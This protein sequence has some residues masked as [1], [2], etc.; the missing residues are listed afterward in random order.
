MW[1]V[2]NLWGR[3]TLGYSEKEMQH[4]HDFV[5]T[6]VRMLTGGSLHHPSCWDK[7]FFYPSYLLSRHVPNVAFQLRDSEQETG[8]HPFEARSAYDLTLGSFQLW[9]EGSIFLP[10]ETQEAHTDTL[11]TMQGI[12]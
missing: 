9:V 10:K 3:A 2:A 7:D 12:V 8:F 4:R 1:Q 5:T 11:G 6:R